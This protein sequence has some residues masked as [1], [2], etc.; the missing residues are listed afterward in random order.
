MG[1]IDKAR[2]SRTKALLRLSDEAVALADR[3]DIDEKKLR[4]VF[5]L[6]SEYHAEI[7]WQIIDFNLS[8]KQVKELCEGGNLE[9]DDDPSSD[10]LPASA[11]K[12]ARAAQSISATAA[13]DVARAILQ[14]EGNAT[15]AKAKLQALCQL[16]S[17][18]ESYLES[19]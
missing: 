13:Q 7:V 5:V 12:M 15:V 6:S 10:R 11:I 9:T 18:A 4:Y 17:E 1:G 16:L 8:S 2:F 14:Q 3:H 19:D